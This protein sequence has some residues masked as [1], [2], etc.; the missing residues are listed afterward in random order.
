[1]QFPIRKGEIFYKVKEINVL[2]GGVLMYAAQEK[3]QIDTEIAEK[4]PFRM[5][6]NDN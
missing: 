5:E 2:C 1:M 4:S 6:T 3:L